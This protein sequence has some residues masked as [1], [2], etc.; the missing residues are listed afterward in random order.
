ME[1]KLQTG[2][3]LQD[4]YFNPTSKTVC[5]TL[6]IRPGRARLYFK[7]GTYPK[8]FSNARENKY[9]KTG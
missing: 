8:G 4:Y 3:S 5:D 9:A 2:D 7:N 6:M 1:R